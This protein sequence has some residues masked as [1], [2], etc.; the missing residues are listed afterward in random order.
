MTVR[1]LLF[2]LI[3]SCA[4]A[5]G[6]PWELSPRLP[7]KAPLVFVGTGVY[8]AW[9]PSVATLSAVEGEWVCATYRRGNGIGIGLSVDGEWWYAPERALRVKLTADYAQLRLTAPSEPLPLS[10]GRLLQTEYQ[11]RYGMWLIRAELIHKQRLWRFSW[12]S[13]AVWFAL[14]W[15]GREEQWEVVLSPPEYQFQTIPPARER[16]LGNARSIA[17]R[18]YG[19]GIRV[20][21]GY[22]LMLARQFPL[23]VAPAFVAG[24][25]LISLARTAAWQRWELGLECTVFWGVSRH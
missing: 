25:S 24:T 21:L 13:P 23:Y 8:S 1:A 3:P 11:L 14:H 9:T 2:V 6:F 17:L 18:P 19:A 22:D 4:A 12:W 20:R 7:V 15:R 16:R 5:Q 10:N